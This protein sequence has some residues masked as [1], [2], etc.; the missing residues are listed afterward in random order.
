MLEFSE[1]EL[2][3]VTLSVKIFILPP[4]IFAV[5]AWRDD[6]DAVLFFDLWDQLIVVKSF[7]SYDVSV[8]DALKKSGSL[9]TFVAA[10]GRKNKPQCIPQ[11]I[12]ESVYF[13]C[14]T[15]LARTKRLLCIAAL[16]IPTGTGMSSD[17]R[18]MQH[19][20]LSIVIF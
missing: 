16:D 10:S 18:A 3:E 9:R 1:K 7:V 8:F 19:H 12:D 11:S 14:K 2:N 15:T 5:F 13:G 20:R 6:S 17:N 4:L